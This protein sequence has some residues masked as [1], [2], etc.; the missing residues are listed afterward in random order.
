MKGIKIIHDT[1]CRQH[2]THET[3]VRISFQDLTNCR[4][5]TSQ[6][7]IAM[8]SGHW[9]SKQTAIIAAFK[10]FAAVITE[11]VSSASS[12]LLQYDIVSIS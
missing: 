8:K 12:S 6:R 1:S 9:N 10:Q 2:F 7:N 11:S 5:P 3:L 4:R